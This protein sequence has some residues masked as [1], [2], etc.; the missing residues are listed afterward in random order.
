V[1]PSVVLPLAVVDVISV[2]WL[3]I[4]ISVI[5]SVVLPLA[6]VDVISVIWLIMILS[7][8]PSVVLPLA[9]VDVIRVIT[10]FVKYP[11]HVIFMYNIFLILLERIYLI[12][13]CKKYEM[14]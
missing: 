6:V 4:I 14:N 2:I 12:Q 9:V 8:I 11:T 5:P 7:V 13:R 3:I 10:L 1:I